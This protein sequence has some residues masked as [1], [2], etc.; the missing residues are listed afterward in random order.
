MGA[1]KE[2]SIQ[3]PKQQSGFKKFFSRKQY[4]AVVPKKSEPLQVASGTI[5]QFASSGKAS[6]SATRAV[7]ISRKNKL[8]L[9]GAWSKNDSSAANTASRPE[10]TVISPSSG[11]SE[12]VQV[13]P[14]QFDPRS[15]R[16]STIRPIHDRSATPSSPGTNVMVSERSPK[17]ESLF[18]WQ[19]NMEQ[20]EELS[21]IQQ[22]Q[23]IKERDGFCR[24]VDKY[25]A[26][27]IHVEGEAAYELGN[28]LGGGVAGVVYEGHRLLPESEYPVRRGSEHPTPSVI[29]TSGGNDLTNRVNSLLSCVPVNMCEADNTL[30]DIAVDAEPFTPTNQMIRDQGSMLTADSHIT[31]GTMNTY[32]TAAH[33]DTVAVEAVHDMVLIDAQDAPSRSKHLA[34]AVTAQ[35][36]GRDFPSDAS[37]TDGFMEETVAI[38]ILNPVGFRTLATDV[39]ATAVVAR[40]GAPMSADCAFGK[41]PMEEKH[42]WWLVN[43]SSRNLRT[44]QRYS[45]DTAA[46]RGVEVDRGSADRGLRISLIAAFKDPISKKL[47]ELPLTRCIEIWGHVPFEASDAQFR[48]VMSAI[49][50]INQGLPPPPIDLAPGRVGTSTSSMESGSLHIQ[51]LKLST[52]TPMVTKRT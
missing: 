12:D 38:K 44:L 40:E 8:G 15:E 31:G 39:T 22:K 17:R 2:M 43:P 32:N 23:L 21:V 51:E 47:R 18:L 24:R 45:V 25:D 49:D 36:K 37:F 14:S 9:L 46:P 13:L 27:V 42:V 20:Q 29:D 33:T 16:I 6:L 7:K 30:D 11:S 28:Y 4:G 41:A 52:P 48:D 50:K 5:P 19:D 26:S 3:Q 34:D 1:P 10:S 35:R